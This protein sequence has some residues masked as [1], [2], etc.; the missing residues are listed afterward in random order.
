MQS[1]SE[2]DSPVAVASAVIVSPLA[3]TGLIEESVQAPDKTV[4]VPI[5]I[6]LD[7]TVIKVPSASVE[8]PDTE[9]SPGSNGVV[10]EGQSLLPRQSPAIRSAGEHG[11]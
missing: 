9:A 10:I 8:V 4:V 1:V 6:P 3:N 7:Y 2:V 11:D 5:L